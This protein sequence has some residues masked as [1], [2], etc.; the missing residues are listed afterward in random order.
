MKKKIA[1]FFNII[2]LSD[3][4][5]ERISGMVSNLKNCQ[6]GKHFWSMTRY[7]DEPWEICDICFSR[8]EFTGEEWD[9]L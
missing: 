6:R 4:Y 3:E 8:R 5:F 7:S 9:A 1:L 2:T